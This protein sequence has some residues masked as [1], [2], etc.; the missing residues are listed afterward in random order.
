MSFRLYVY[1]CLF[2]SSCG[3]LAGGLIAR[4]VPL[5]HLSVPAVWWLA[6][7]SGLGLALSLVDA[8]AGLSARR[9]LA[10]G[11]R[12]LTGLVCG[13]VGGAAGSLLARSVREVPRPEAAWLVGLLAGAS[14]G[15][16]DLLASVALVKHPGGALRKLRNGL[17]GGAL[18]GGLGCS[19][20]VG[21]RSLWPGL[22]MDPGSQD[23]WTPSAVEAAAVG[24]CTG[25]IVGLAQVLLRDAWLRVEVGPRS[26]RQ[27]LLSRPETT[28]GHSASC[29][30]ALSGDGEVAPVHARIVRHGGDYVVADAGTAAGT[31]VNERRLDTPVVLHSGDLIRV[32]RNRVLFLRR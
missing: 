8:L 9:I 22:A 19:A 27:L 31:F 23:T 14:A 26:G 7:G 5:G 21:L 6:V 4:L 12:G 13:A 2:W 3:A 20:I 15:I 32:G 16:A 17:V 10:V 1:H 11:L 28:L 29:D 24:A 30:V 18:G 25:L